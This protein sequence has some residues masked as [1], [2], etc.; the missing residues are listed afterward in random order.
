L[1]LVPGC[2]TNRVWGCCL[3]YV[4]VHLA[5]LPLGTPTLRMGAHPCFPK[6]HT[7][8]AHTLSFSSPLPRTPFPPTPHPLAQQKHVPTLSEDKRTKKV[9]PM[10]YLVERAAVDPDTRWRRTF[11]LGSKAELLVVIKQPEGL[12]GP[13]FVNLVTDTA[14]DV[15]LHWGYCM[16]GGCCVLLGRGGG[17][18]TWATACQVWREE[19][20]GSRRGEGGWGAAPGLLH[21]R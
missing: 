10:E 1:T 5:A 2:L 8:P 20:E 17:G 19:G 18:C 6:T 21:A 16:P 14:S 9:K 3:W 15:V 13:A 12:E 7:N 11:Q 4:H